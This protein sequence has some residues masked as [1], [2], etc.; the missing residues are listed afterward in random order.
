[1]NLPKIIENLRC[2]RCGQARMIRV[3]VMPMRSRPGCSEVQYRCTECDEVVKQ[4]EDDRF[5]D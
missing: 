2:P 4:T 1:M 3:S 5:R